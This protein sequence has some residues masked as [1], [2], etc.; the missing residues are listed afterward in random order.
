MSL[1]IS[2]NLVYL[3][4]P[5]IAVMCCVYLALAKTRSKQTEE[6]L[7][8]HQPLELVTSVLIVSLFIAFALSVLFAFIAFINLLVSLF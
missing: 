7:V 6:S 2:V 3:L 8:S 4:P 1:S 5:V